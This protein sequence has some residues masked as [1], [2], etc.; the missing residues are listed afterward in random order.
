MP[1]IGLGMLLI[2]FQLTELTLFAGTWKSQPGQVEVAV[3]HALRSGYRSIDT[4]T[5]Y[6]NEAEVGVGLVATG[7]Y[8]I[9]TPLFKRYFYSKEP[10][11]G[12]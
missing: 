11:A 4:A 8:N 12:G 10:P 5:A 9:L 6:E 1:I 7:A 2:R 3:E